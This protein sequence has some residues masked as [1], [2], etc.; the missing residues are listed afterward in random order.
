MESNTA[1][2]FNLH[3]LTALTVDVPAAFLLLCKVNHIDPADALKQFAGDVCQHPF[4]TG[5]SDE[6]EMAKGYFIRAYGQQYEKPS[7]FNELADLRKEWKGHHH[8]QEYKELYST[9]INELNTI[10]Q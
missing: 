7:I 5:G 9:K 3:D 2:D 8:M 1:T 6:R 4:I 10:V